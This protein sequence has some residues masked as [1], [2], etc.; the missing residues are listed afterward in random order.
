MN[1]VLLT[2][3]S[4]LQ[5]RRL[6]SSWNAIDGSVTGYGLGFVLTTALLKAAGIGLSAGTAAIGGSP[7]VRC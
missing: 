1:T 7:L 3:A 2:S 6:G 5:L 4:H